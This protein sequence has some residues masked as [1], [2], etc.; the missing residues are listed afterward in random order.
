LGCAD[1]SLG[2]IAKPGAQNPAD[3]INALGGLLG[4]KKKP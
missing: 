4:K 2:S 1:G 3:A